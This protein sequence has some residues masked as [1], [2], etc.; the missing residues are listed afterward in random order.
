MLLRH[1]SCSQ[2]PGRRVLGCEAA[3]LLPRRSWRAGAPPSN[4]GLCP[5]RTPPHATLPAAPLQDFTMEVREELPK[6]VLSQ[7]LRAIL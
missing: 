4:F 5:P 7:L 3:V 1:M 6:H 2:R